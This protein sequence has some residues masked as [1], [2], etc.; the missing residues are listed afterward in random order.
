MAEGVRGHD[1]GFHDE[2]GA[3]FAGLAGAGMLKLD[4]LFPHPLYRGSEGQYFELK[5]Y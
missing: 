1:H 5:T 3:K 4:L 2:S